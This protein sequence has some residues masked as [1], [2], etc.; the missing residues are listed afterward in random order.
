VENW[1]KFVEKLRRR[2]RGDRRQE[3]GGMRQETGDRR[4]NV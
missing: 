4:Y 2:R 3:T 1:A